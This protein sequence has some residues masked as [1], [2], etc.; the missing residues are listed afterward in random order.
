MPRTPP[1]GSR[2]TWTARLTYCDGLEAYRVSTV[3]V[4]REPWGTFVTDEE[5]GTMLER[6]PLAVRSMVALG[7]RL[8]RFEPHR[9]VDVGPVNV[10]H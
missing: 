5:A 7:M 4:F 9:S 10:V 3:G 2:V 1:P 8:A 6:L